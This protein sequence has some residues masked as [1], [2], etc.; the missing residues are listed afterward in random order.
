MLFS[1]IGS[2]A[3]LTIEPPGLIF[4]QCQISG[5]E[6]RCFLDTGARVSTLGILNDTKNFPVTGNE[7]FGGLS[8]ILSSRK[9]VAASI[10]QS[11]Q[12]VARDFPMMIPD[13]NDEM[14]DSP[15]LGSDF[16]FRASRPHESVCYSFDDG[17]L[18]STPEESTKGSP[19][20][21]TLIRGVT[22][23]MVVQIGSESLLSLW[24]TGAERTLI[25]SKVL[26]RH[27][28]VC[29]PEAEEGVLLDSVGQV[30]HSGR[31]ICKKIQIGS[32]S[33]E[34]V[35]VDGLDLGPAAER[36]Q[37]PVQ[38]IIGMNL[39]AQKNWCL[40]VHDANWSAT[41][42]QKQGWYQLLIETDRGVVSTK[43]SDPLHLPDPVLPDVTDSPD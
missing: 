35:Q 21:L 43:S 28:D 9:V 19:N 39:I 34:N 36:A 33:F 6:D 2:A 41:P 24:D 16:I 31:F 22:P 29:K 20:K 30:I 17:T 4:V 14:N 42:L 32:L 27:P 26:L 23:G 13:E 40:N 7:T 3:Q 15:T 1:D 38:A 12:L 25:D 37:A 5:F 18:L 10:V 8:G 11:G